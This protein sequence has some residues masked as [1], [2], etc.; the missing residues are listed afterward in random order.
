[1]YDISAEKSTVVPMD[2]TSF[3]GSD[4]DDEP[5]E[6]VQLISSSDQCS[7]GDDEEKLHGLSQEEEAN[8]SATVY[9]CG[10]EKKAVMQ[11]I[12][13]A[14]RGKE[15]ID[16]SLYEYSASIVIVPKA[17]KNTKTN[18]QET[19]NVTYL[20]ESI[21]PGRLTNATIQFH[22]KHPLF[23]SHCQRVRSKSKIP[24]TVLSPPKPP[25][26]KPSELTAE[27]IKTARIFTRYILV[28]FRPWTENGGTLPG[29]LKWLELCHFMENLEFSED[30]AGPPTDAEIV[31]RRWIENASQGFRRREKP[32]I[33][34]I[35]VGL[36]LAGGKTIFP[37]IWLLRGIPSRM[38]LRPLNP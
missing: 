25:S 9:S 36:P 28:L 13:Y 37:E 38:T 1:M 17:D 27:W 19:E 26:S 18:V 23:Q 20:E 34:Y 29:S 35:D 10:K 7:A 2:R 30:R 15:L 22:P 5:E 32:P 6:F 3:D 4:S 33:F 24:V 21:G 16:F 8:D 12:H 11:H 31:R 14:F